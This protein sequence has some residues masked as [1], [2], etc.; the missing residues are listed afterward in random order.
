MSNQTMSLSKV[1]LFAVL[2]SAVF[3]SRVGM[4]TAA[5]SQK[6][7]KD[8][9]FEEIVAKAK[10]G[11]ADAQLYLAQGHAG[12]S[13]G[14]PHNKQESH[15]WYVAAATNNVPEAQLYLGKYYYDEV[16]STRGYTQKDKAKR[17]QSAP[18]ALS[19]LVKA[20]KQGSYGAWVFLGQAFED[21]TVFAKDPVEAYKWYHLAIE[22][23]NRPIGAPVTSRNA[24]SLKLAPAQIELA[25]R[26]ALEFWESLGEEKKPTALK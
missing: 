11:D 10:A 16:T 23:G 4:L 22:K 2:A 5:E 14:V 15:R 17:Q 1:V 19:W 25:K 21:G 26:R 9:P 13:T 7:L 24:L 20:A 12:L 18:I 8:T 6:L 3:L